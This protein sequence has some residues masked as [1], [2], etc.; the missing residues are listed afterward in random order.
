[1]GKNG[2]LSPVSLLIFL[3]LV[4]PVVVI[5]YLDFPNGAVAG[6]AWLG[7][8]ISVWSA[9][10]LTLA[11]SRTP[12]PR[13]SWMLW[14]YT[15]A[16]TGFPA[17]FQVLLGVFPSTAPGQTA[18]GFGRAY[19][20]VAIG[21]VAYEIGCKISRFLPD[22]RDVKVDLGGLGGSRA[23]AA[24]TVLGS[25]VAWYMIMMTGPEILFGTREDV[26][27]IRE[28]HWPNMSVLAVLVAMQYVPALFYVNSCRLR[29]FKKGWLAGAL[30]LFASVSALIA[31][32]PITSPR[33]QSGTV[34]L[35]LA[36][37][38]GLFERRRITKVNAVAVTLLVIFAFPYTDAFRGSTKSDYSSY[39]DVVTRKGDY[40]SMAQMA[41]IVDFVELHGDAGGRQFLGVV[42]VAI[43]RS[44]WAEK[45]IDTGTLVA[46]ERGY[47]FTN[48]SAPIWGEM[49]INFGV[50]GLILGAAGLG[51]MFTRLDD[52]SSRAGADSIL[53]IQYGVIPFYLL[54]LLRGSLM[55][56]SAAL[57][58]MLSVIALVR[59]ES[60][61]KSVRSISCEQPVTL[62]VQPGVEL[63]RTAGIR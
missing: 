12:T 43:P 7:V 9:T 20:V 61:V 22:R 60:Y 41:N 1:M 5:Y 58:L 13:Y 27:R 31:V 56:A 53:R 28:H 59:L 26:R 39:L 29:G 49:Y 55:Q 45:P 38:Y 47:E 37:G 10:R 57:F 16:F 48:L 19:V 50:L 21:L 24:L 15:Y 63:C 25:L 2:R 34:I 30:K 33:I 6:S 32:N 23:L 17:L 36:C 8:C 11:L 40:D 18:E 46:L 42:A 52:L 14:L 3:M 44:V 62:L 54:I 35:S 51:V 4:S